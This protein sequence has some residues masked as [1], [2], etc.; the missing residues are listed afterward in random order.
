M[1]SLFARDPDVILAA[2]TYLKAYAIDWILTPN[3]PHALCHAAGD[4]R[5]IRCQDPGRLFHEPPGR[6]DLI[7]DRPRNTGFF[8]RA[9]HS[10]Y[11]VFPDVSQKTQKGNAEKP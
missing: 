8:P 11:W 5:L 6:R 3:E 10:L 2:D 1:A 9:D 4:H 7:P